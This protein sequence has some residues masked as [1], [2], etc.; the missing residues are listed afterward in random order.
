MGANTE[1]VAKMK[2]QLRKWDEELDAL[3]ARGEKASEEAREAFHYQLK[4]LRA[5]R[6]GISCPRRWEPPRLDSEGV[7]S[8]VPTPNT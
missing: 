7:K 6:A 5:S 1:Y 2:E 4:G 3:N 8:W